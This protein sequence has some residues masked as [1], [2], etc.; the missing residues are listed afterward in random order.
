MSSQASSSD[1]GLDLDYNEDQEAIASAI[2]RFCESQCDTDTVKNLNGSFPKHLWQELAALGVFSPATPEGAEMGGALEVCAICE[3]LGRH[4]FPGPVS[5]TYLAMQVLEENDRANI[6]TGESIVSVSQA[7]NALLPF[8]TEADIFLVIDGS[9][10][11]RA[12]TPT[13]VQ[14]VS[15]LGDEPWGKDRLVTD[16]KPLTGANRALTMNAI[17][18]TAY[19]TGAGKQLVKEAA[20]YAA[21]R[22][23]FGKSLGEFQ[24]VAH[25][26][27]DSQINLTAAQTL[28][29]AAAS[30][31]DS[32]DTEGAASHAAAARISGERAAL[33]A[34]FACHQVFA[35][36][37]IT[38]EGP[39][40]HISRRIRQ[41]ASSPPSQAHAAAHLVQH[42]QLGNDL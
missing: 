1:T 28:A 32:G 40:F 36:I 14:P 10:I 29:R 27:A 5:A 20:E 15:T 37:G 42:I 25:P 39:A 23:Q 35:G 4:T 9:D 18:T 12:A 7:G 38:L 24:A 3:S 31:L 22:K 2:D 41:L 30:C 16:A 26:L 34:A 21:V 11:Y 33:Q 6:A 17:A 8:G 13:A 19:L